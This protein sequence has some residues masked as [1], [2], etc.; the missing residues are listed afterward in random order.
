MS[1]QEEKLQIIHELV[2]EL[3]N[4]TN[5]VEKKMES[6]ADHLIQLEK[7]LETLESRMDDQPIVQCD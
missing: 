4:S 2:K 1:S 3:L 7:R 6:F 5:Q